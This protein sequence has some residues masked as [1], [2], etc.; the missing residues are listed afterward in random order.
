[1]GSHPVPSPS[2]CGSLESCWRQHPL[3]RLV[4]VT[5]LSCRPAPESPDVALVRTPPPPVFRPTQGDADPIE[6]Q[7]PGLQ[8]L[9]PPAQSWLEQLNLQEL[10]E[11]RFSTGVPQNF[12]K[13]NT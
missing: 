8:Q 3:L 6:A 13:C 10:L 4:K 2:P 9:P 7:G 5:E 11:Q 1:M 12:F